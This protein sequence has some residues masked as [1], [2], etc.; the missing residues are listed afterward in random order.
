MPQRFFSSTGNMFTYQANEAL[1]PIL[2]AVIQGNLEQFIQA[3]ANLEDVE[4]NH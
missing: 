3:I 1:H 2:E 4:V